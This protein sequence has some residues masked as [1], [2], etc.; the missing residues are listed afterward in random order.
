MKTLAKA[1]GIVAVLILFVGT[2]AFLYQKSMEQPVVFKTA[3]PVI[4]DIVKKAV[5]TGTIVPRKEI[6]VKPQISGLIEK[7]HVR[8]G[9]S[10]KNGDPIARVKVIPNMVS[11]NQAESRLNKARIDVEDTK[12]SYDRWGKLI[13]KGIVPESEFQKYEMAYIK[14]KEELSAAETNLQLIKD[15]IAKNRGGDT[16]TIIRSTIDGMV[17]DIPVEEGNFVIETNTYNDGTTIAVVADMG[18]MVFEGKVDETEVGKI[19]PGMDLILTIGAIENETYTARLEYIAPKGVEEKG[20]VQFEIKANIQL[21]PDRFL[22]AGY[23]ANADIVLERKDNVLSLD[24]SV[25]QFDNNASPYVEIETSPQQFEKRIIEV[26]LSDG[27]HIEVV[28]G[29]T[30]DNKLKIPR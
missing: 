30:A 23:S 19:R 11:L 14:A 16:N 26:G 20:A 8:P 22:R 27:I 9:Q 15:G 12:T 24:E 7:I 29:L 1:A 28:A 10:V 25:L 6:E 21:K 3:S 4:M 18:K 13:D 2:L 5:A 17:L